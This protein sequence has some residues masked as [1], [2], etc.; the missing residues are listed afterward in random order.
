MPPNKIG[1]VLAAFEANIDK[2]RRHGGATSKTFL[3]NIATLR[4]KPSSESRVLSQT[5]TA[6]ELAPRSVSPQ[7]SLEES[8]IS[9]EVEQPKPVARSI[10]RKDGRF[11]ANSAAQ[12]QPEPKDCEQAVPGVG[13]P[14]RIVAKPVEK[15][16]S[17]RKLVRRKS[18]GGSK[19]CINPGRSR[20]RS[21]APVQRSRSL[22]ARSRQ[23]TDETNSLLMDQIKR[24][25]EILTD[26]SSVHSRNSGY[27]FGDEGSV[28]DGEDHT[29]SSVGTYDFNG[30]S[31][32]FDQSNAGLGDDDEEMDYAVPVE[33]PR[34]ERQSLFGRMKHW[35]EHEHDPDS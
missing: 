11:V 3:N 21:K 15:S 24:S 31:V 1:S 9:A 4:S 30:S 18:A 33:I 7:T 22:G 2:N 28:I 19:R 14:T 26:I 6:K 10:L 13:V 35:S 5:L 27:V 25:K 17:K 16:G 8:T 34:E 32:A 20:S 29:Y 23:A 12:Q